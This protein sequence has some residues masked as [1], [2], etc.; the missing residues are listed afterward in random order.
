M[1]YLVGGCG[2]LVGECV[3]GA[4]DDSREDGG[5]KGERGWL[6]VVGWGCMVVGAPLGGVKRGT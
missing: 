5:V 2:G 1:G 3:E 4:L 6:A